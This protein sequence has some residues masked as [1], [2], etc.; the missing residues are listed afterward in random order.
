MNY[1]INLATYLGQNES[2]AYDSEKRYK[3]VFMYLGIE[4]EKIRK[5]G[6]RAK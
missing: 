2:D 4:T 5:S 6:R 3:T 1:S